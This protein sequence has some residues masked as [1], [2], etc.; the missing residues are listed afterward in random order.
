M[1]DL[2]AAFKASLE[3]SGVTTPTADEAKEKPAA[4]GGARRGPKRT[5][6][7]HG[8][9]CNGGARATRNKALLP[10]GH[11]I[12]GA[13]YGARF[14]CLNRR[15]AFAYG[16]VAEGRRRATV[17]A[18]TVAMTSSTIAARTRAKGLAPAGRA[19]GEGVVF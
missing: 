3:K 12:G 6:A 7:R 4:R 9:R 18:A 19:D 13:N 15:F 17:L 8:R 5:R 1:I 2:T 10:H 14:A 11:R 16:R